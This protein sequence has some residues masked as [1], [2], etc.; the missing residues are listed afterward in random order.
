MGIPIGD[1]GRVHEAGVHPLPRER[2]RQMPRVTDEEAA[3]IRERG[4]HPPLHVEVGRPADI[5]HADVGSEP[6]VYES[7]H[8]VACRRVGDPGMGLVDVDE[9]D[10]AI[11]GQRPEEDDPPSGRRR[12]FPPPAPA[13]KRVGRPRQRSV[14]RRFRHRAPHPWRTG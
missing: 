6:L 3:T 11:F 14:P 2:A 5:V 10:P 8:R 1:F 7:G 12:R 9:D 13:A 4:D